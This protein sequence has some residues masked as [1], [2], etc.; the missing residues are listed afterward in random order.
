MRI[1]FIL[2]RGGSRLPRPKKYHTKQSDAI[3][4]YMASLSDKPVTAWQIAEHFRALGVPV[5]TATIYRRLDELIESGKVRKYIMDG[6]A[7]A[8]YLYTGGG[9]RSRRLQLKCETCGGFLQVECDFPGEL[10]R[11][12][13]AAHGFRIDTGKIV[14]YGKCESCAARD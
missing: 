13:A 7:C 4:S 10:E 14:L 2:M 9:L 3:I 5:G 8:Y 12:V 1:I 11:H 6:E